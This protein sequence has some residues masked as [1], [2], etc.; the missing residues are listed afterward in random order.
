MNFLRAP[1][2]CLAVF[3]K[4]PF[5][6]GDSELFSQYLGAATISADFTGSEASLQSISFAGCT[7]YAHALGPAPTIAGTSAVQ[8]LQQI[9]VDGICQ[10]CTSLSQARVDSCCAVPSSVDCFESFAPGKA[11]KT[12]ASNPASTTPAGSPAT[13]TGGANTQTTSKSGGDRTHVVSFG[14]TPFSLFGILILSDFR[15]LFLGLSW[16]FWAFSGGHCKIE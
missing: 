2:F 13:A 3:I 10:L 4:V 11:Q 14:N 9:Q 5:V 12:P 8:Q 1:L 6:L 15:L 16:L 7:N